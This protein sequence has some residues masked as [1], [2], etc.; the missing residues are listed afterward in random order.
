MESTTIE[1]FRRPEVNLDLTSPENITSPSQ[2]P[3][4]V[5]GEGQGEN[6]KSPLPLGEGQGEGISE[7]GR[8][9][10]TFRLE[11]SNTN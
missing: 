1:V 5:P 3:W 4:S 11:A 6:V 10:K 9:V 8:L 2:Q 7:K